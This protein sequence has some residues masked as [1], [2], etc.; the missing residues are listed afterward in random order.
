[1]GTRFSF[2]DPNQI[3]EEEYAR[4]YR[5]VEH[6]LFKYRRLI[7]DSLQQEW[8]N[9]DARELHEYV[10][11]ADRPEEILRQVADGIFGIAF[12]DALRLAIWHVADYLTV[13]HVRGY[14][15]QWSNK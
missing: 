5:A 7:V 6:D 9:A 1:M 8:H 14:W 2:D 11:E 12:N 15:P 10:A 4:I 3:Y 13:Q